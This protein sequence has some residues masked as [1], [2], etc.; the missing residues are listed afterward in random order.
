MWLFSSGPLA[1]GPG[2]G[3]DDPELEPGEIGEF[4]ESIHPRDHRV[5]FGALDPGRLGFA[6]RALRKL[7]A[8]RAVLPVGDFRDWDEIEAWAG[9]IARALGTP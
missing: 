2:A 3:L 9:S 5:F 6:H 4:R 7:P 8:A 1:L